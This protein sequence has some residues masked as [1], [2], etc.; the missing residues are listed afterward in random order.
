MESHV[1]LP[2]GKK[3]ASDLIFPETTLEV[4][5]PL[6]K[7]APGLGCGAPAT[8]A[9]LKLLAISTVYPTP[10]SS[11]HGEFGSVEALYRRQLFFF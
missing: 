8:A 6:T 1:G 9:L 10:C 7:R 2:E 11:G 3:G 5:H 4:P